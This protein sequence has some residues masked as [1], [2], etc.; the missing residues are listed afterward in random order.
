MKYLMI[1]ISLLPIFLSSCTFFEEKTAVLWTDRP[2]FAAYVEVYNA[3]QDEYHIELKFRQDPGKTLMQETE[4]ADLVIGEGFTS[5]DIITQFSD[6][7][8]LFEEDTINQ[9]LFYTQLL[10]I[11]K[12]E[13]EQL[14]LPVSFSLP[15]L[16]FN[17]EKYVEEQSSF[18][19]N[20]EQ[21]RQASIKFNEESK[22]R[23]RIMGFVPWW[24]PD[25]LYTQAILQ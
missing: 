3:Q 22:P 2:E 23:R 19:L 12:R 13:E 5:R 25:F 15:V 18:L 17:T 21:I 16:I 10:K 24:S 6:L 8:K 7:S 4:Q 20:A 11:G 9:R 1:L 14:I